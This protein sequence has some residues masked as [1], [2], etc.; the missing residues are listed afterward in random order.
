[1]HWSRI[2]AMPLEVLLSLV[3]RALVRLDRWLSR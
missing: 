3:L 1:M 2:I